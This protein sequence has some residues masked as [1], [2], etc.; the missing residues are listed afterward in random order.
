MSWQLFWQVLIGVV[1]A[2]FAVRVVATF[3]VTEWLENRRKW[4]KEALTAICPH[5]TAYV[6]ADGN[7]EIRC[8][9]VS[10]PGTIQAQCQRCGLVVSSIHVA[11]SVMEE[12][13]RDP[14]GLVKREHLFIK[15]AKRYYRLREPK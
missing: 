4:R 14:I 10:P 3:N 7:P 13:G 12:W 5:A 8:L 6:N 15:K 9:I 2:V 11:E 1:V